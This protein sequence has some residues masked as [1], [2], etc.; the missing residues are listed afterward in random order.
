MDPLK[1]LLYIDYVDF[2]RMWDAS[3]NFAMIVIKDL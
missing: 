2:S 1:G 3:N